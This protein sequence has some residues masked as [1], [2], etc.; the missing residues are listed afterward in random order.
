MSRSHAF[1]RSFS[2]RQYFPVRATSKPFAQDT[3][4]MD[5]I[6]LSLLILQLGIGLTFAVH[7]AQKVFGWWG[8][9]G[10]AGRS[11]TSHAR[12]SAGSRPSTDRSG[13]SARTSRTV[14][15]RYHSIV[16][17]DAPS[18]AFAAR[19]SS[20]ARPSVSCPRESDAHRSGCP[21]SG[22]QRSVESG[23][24]TISSAPCRRGVGAGQ[25]TRCWALLFGVG[26]ILCNWLA[27]KDSNLQSP[28][29]ESDDVNQVCQ[30][31]FELSPAPRAV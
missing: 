25:A 8:G 10:L 11:S 27:R 29:P 20:T 18:A 6:T 3:G 24:Q 7:G 23:A 19:N 30:P 12:N 26:R 4:I 22:A 28:D 1:L 17:G 9:P 21:E 14:I 31:I 13:P 16:R 15:I 5:T 2:P